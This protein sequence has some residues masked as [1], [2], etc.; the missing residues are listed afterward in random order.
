MQRS[1]RSDR[2][3]TG[4][5]GNAG[6]RFGSAVSGPSSSPLFLLSSM[7]LA[8]AAHL[9]VTSD[10]RS[11]HPV[12]LLWALGVAACVLWSGGLV[13]YGY[14]LRVLRRRFLS[15]GSPAEEQR[16]AISMGRLR[17]RGRP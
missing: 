12:G 11:E 6:V 10:L 16:S 1:A 17:V 9:V 5:T 14:S 3:W 15:A 7:S 13:W 2:P 4:S 8:L